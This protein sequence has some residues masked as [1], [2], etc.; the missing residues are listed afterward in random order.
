[1]HCGASLGDPVTICACAVHFCQESLEQGLMSPPDLTI[2]RSG[3]PSFMMFQSLE[4]GFMSLM[5]L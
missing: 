4:K 2:D 5:I 3:N 1:M